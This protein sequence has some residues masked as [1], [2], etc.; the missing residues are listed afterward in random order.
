[1]KANADVDFEISDEDMGVLKKVKRIGY[2]DSS[3]FP[4]FGGKL[5]TGGD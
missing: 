2:G 3:F 4:V 5:K 1:M